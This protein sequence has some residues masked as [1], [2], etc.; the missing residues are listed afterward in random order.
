MQLRGRAIGLLTISSDKV[1]EYT[2]AEATLTQAFANEVTIAVE[3]ARLFSELQSMAT[4]DSLTNLLNRRHFISLAKTEFQRARRYRQ[5]LSIILLDI[6]HFKRIN[7][8][9]GHPVGDQVLSGFARIFEENLRQVDLVGRYGGEEFIALLPNTN[10]QNAQ[11]VANRVL[12]QI[13]NTPILTDAGPI[14][15][16]ASLGVAEMDNKCP[17]I[18]TLLKF[19][20]RAA[21][22]AKQSGKNRV[23]I[24]E[25]E[26][27]Q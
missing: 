5:P 27:L 2:E 15:I 21:Y 8:V 24:S 19:A 11:I 3:N 17:D 1:N 12:A 14:Q 23:S 4:T 13:T 7:D 16:T 10:L 18:F 25:E 20:D 22:A 6:D 9:Y 26:Q